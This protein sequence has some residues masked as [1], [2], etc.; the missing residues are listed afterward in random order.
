L[1]IPTG[2]QMVTR[3]SGWPCKAAA[4]VES[5]LGRFLRV[6]QRG[7]EKAHTGQHDKRLHFDFA[8]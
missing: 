1:D 6:H 4:N 7:R 5:E 2:V 3:I 8:S